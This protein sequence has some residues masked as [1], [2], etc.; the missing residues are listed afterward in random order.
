MI[1]LCF[2]FGQVVRKTP[3]SD[4][5]L[6]IK[7]VLKMDTPDHLIKQFYGQKFLSGWLKVKHSVRF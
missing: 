1:Q 5:D 3:I 2:D 6:T 4:H 7:P